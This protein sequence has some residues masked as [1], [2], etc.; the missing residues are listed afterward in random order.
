MSHSRHHEHLIL[1]QSSI[2]VVNPPHNITVE[3]TIISV[4][5]NIVRCCI[6]DVLRIA[7]ANAI[8]PRKPAVIIIDVIVH[9]SNCIVSAVLNEQ[10]LVSV[11]NIVVRKQTENANSK[12]M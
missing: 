8:A 10:W 6:V 7:N 12:N 5:E 9:H 2:C 1:S 11:A 4:V 3:M